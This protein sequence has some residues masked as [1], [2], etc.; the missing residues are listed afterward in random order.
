MNPDLPAEPERIVNKAIEKDRKLRYQH[1]SDIRSDLQRLKR[2]MDLC[3]LSM[4]NSQNAAPRAESALPPT[5]LPALPAT[6][7]W[8]R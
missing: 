7:P 6:P 3:Q 2:D 1:A 8:Y 4:V 5:A